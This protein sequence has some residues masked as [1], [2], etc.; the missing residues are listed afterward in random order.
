MD[1]QNTTNSAHLVINLR[2][3]DDGIYDRKADKEAYII[4]ILG[5]TKQK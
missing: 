1:Q 2:D 3:V 4:I 5:L